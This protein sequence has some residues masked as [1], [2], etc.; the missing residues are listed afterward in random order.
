MNL[1]ELQQKQQELKEEQQ[2]TFIDKIKADI[3]YLCEK[4]NRKDYKPTIHEQQQL[5]AI[6]DIINNLI[7]WF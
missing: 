3:V 4:A 5:K 7:N 2:N 1:A 6:A